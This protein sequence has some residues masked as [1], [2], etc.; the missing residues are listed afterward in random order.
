MPQWIPGHVLHR[1]WRAGGLAWTSNYLGH[2]SENHNLWEMV[3][4]VKS[5]M[6]N[7][8][9]P[10]VVTSTNK[11][12]R[13]TYLVK[14]H[15]GGAGGLGWQP[16]FPLPNDINLY[17]CKIRPVARH[18]SAACTRNFQLNWNMTLTGCFMGFLDWS[19]LW[20]DRVKHWML[21]EVFA[22]LG[23]LQ[24]CTIG[25]P[26]IC[27]V[28]MKYEPHGLVLKA[29]M[30]AISASSWGKPETWVL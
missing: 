1:L 5:F 26:R 24:R 13:L 28:L 25:F 12:W 2:S 23:K 21:H 10:V 16:A 8:I 4:L 15:W 18:F 22:L 17:P 30:C 14:C 11:N 9:W 6:F 29:S 20:R 3:T 19:C 7:L 27:I